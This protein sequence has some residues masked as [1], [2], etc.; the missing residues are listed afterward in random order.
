MTT[1]KE[2]FEHIVD[3]I[4]MAAHQLNELCKGVERVEDALEGK[5]NL[6]PHEKAILEFGE[7]LTDLNLGELDNLTY[8]I[9][10]IQKKDYYNEL[11]KI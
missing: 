7:D 2:R 3:Q 10:Q 4:S 11:D 6:L 5:E 1:V 8:S 9:F